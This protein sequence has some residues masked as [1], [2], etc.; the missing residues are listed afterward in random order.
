MTVFEH[1]KRILFSVCAVLL[2][3]SLLCACGKKPVVTAPVQDKPSD[4]GIIVYGSDSY[5]SADTPVLVAKDT[6]KGTMTFFNRQVGREYTLEYDGTTGIYDKYG[7]TLSLPQI[8]IGDLVDVKFIKTKKHLT[9]IQ[10]SSD[11]WSIDST[12]R[13]EIN[14]VKHEVTIGEDIYK[15]SSDAKFFSGEK[16]IALQDIVDTD[17]LSFRGENSTVYSVVVTKGHGYLRLTGH[18]SFVGGWI[19]VGNSV[20]KKVT[21]EMLITVS[22]G[23]YQVKISNEGTVAQKN[24]VINRN[25]ESSLDFS[26]VVFEEAKK[27]TVLF[28]VTPS[29]AEVFIDGEKVDISKG[30]ELTYGIHQMICRAD[31]YTS[32]TQYLNVGQ[33]S[34]GITIDLEKESA[35]A[36]DKK[37]DTKKEETKTDSDKD[38]TDNKTDDK[39]DDKSDDKSDEKKDETNTTSTYYKMYVDAPEKVEVYVDGSYIGIS[40]CSMKKAPGTHVITLSKEGYIT[41]SYTVNVDTEDRDISYSFVDLV[42]N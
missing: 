27:G 42:A 15:I 5:D 12:N 2:C 41:K 22:E 35:N 40:P 34:A 14:S 1:K 28:S 6:E 17:T 23:S 32:V 8:E 37:E 19:E 38:K 31:G 9:S 33:A 25:S 16:E 21:D 11:T 24:V 13:Y 30:V 18:Q 20:I 3:L 7:A 39:T 29:K 10:L 36:S 26:D 4:T